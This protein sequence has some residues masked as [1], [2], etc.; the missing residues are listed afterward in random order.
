MQKIMKTYQIYMM[1]ALALALAGCAS[2]EEVAAD[3]DEVQAVA[4]GVL[5]ARIDNSGDTRVSMAGLKLDWDTNDQIG[6]VFV[7][8]A[9]QTSIQAFTYDSKKTLDDGSEVAAFTGTLPSGSYTIATAY[10]PYSEE[11]AYSDG[12]VNVS[13]DETLTMDKAVVPMV[14]TMVTDNEFRFKAVGALLAVKVRGLE[15]EWFKQAKLTSSTTNLTAGTI[16]T[17]QPSYTA[18]SSSASSTLQYVIASVDGIKTFYFPLPTQKLSDL[19]FVLKG[20][21]DTSNDVTVKFN[22]FTPE[23]NTKYMKVIEID[24]SR[25]RV[26]DAITLANCKLEA[27]GEASVSLTDNEPE[28]YI[29]KNKESNNTETVKLAVTNVG[30]SEIDVKERDDQDFTGAVAAGNVKVYNEDSNT[31]NWYFKLPDSHVIFDTHSTDVVETYSLIVN[32]AKSFTL[33]QNVEL[34]DR[35]SDAGSIYV[36]GSLETLTIDGTV[37]Y[38]YNNRY[39]KLFADVDKI[40]ISSPQSSGGIKK[41]CLYPDYSSKVQIGQI[42]IDKNVQLMMQLDEA[43]TFKV[44]YGDNEPQEI[45]F[46]ANS[47]SSYY[48]VDEDGNIAKGSSH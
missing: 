32:A 19:S 18:S 11:D 2:N 6:V 7:D 44:S 28:F 27:T 48:Y 29:P 42:S 35:D 20:M 1:A 40:I 41:I 22:E 14:G 34:T 31:A 46:P 37:Q 3:A 36:R 25:L 16:L 9:N 45:E 24:D 47:P 17:D 26:T 43:R 12:A 23:S 21:A 8:E 38:N 15:H 5:Y 33:G 30:K 10:Y 4:E 39:V 13:F